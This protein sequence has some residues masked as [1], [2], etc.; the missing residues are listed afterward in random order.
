M[1]EN[2]SMPPFLKFI[3][4]PFIVIIFIV[5]FLVPSVNTATVQFTSEKLS[6][7]L[8]W[9]SNNGYMAWASGGLSTGQIP[10]ANSSSTVTGDSGLTY[11]SGV[12]KVGSISGNTTQFKIDNAY[13]TALSTVA[14]MVGV[15]TSGD[16]VPGSSGYWVKQGENGK[17]LYATSDNVAQDDIQYALN[18]AAVNTGMVALTNGVFW[19][20]KQ[21]GQTYAIKIPRAYFGDINPGLNG[22]GMR[23]VTPIGLK[24]NYNGTIIAL[25]SGQNC[26]VIQIGDDAVGIYANE[27]TY[28]SDLFIIG[29]RDSQTSGSG[30]NIRPNMNLGWIYHCKILYCKD[31]GIYSENNRY[32]SIY[33]CNADGNGKDGIFLDGGY[34]NNI[35]DGWAWSNGYSGLYFGGGGYSNHV[36]GFRAMCNNTV[37]GLGGIR[38]N[39]T[40]NILTSCSSW[41]EM[42]PGSK[43]QDYGVMIEGT[44]T[45]T[46]I[47]GCNLGVGLLANQFGA[48]YQAAGVTLTKYIDNIGLDDRQVGT[49]TIIIG[50]TS[51]VISHTLGGIPI[52]I[53][54]AFTNNT[55]VTKA[56]WTANSSN[57]TVNVDQ[58][59]T[60]DNQTFSYIARTN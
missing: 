36:I 50:S 26:D 60:T 45:N 43:R 3:L 29:N 55:T 51:T 59:P 12:L 27:S 16:D 37:A 53:S 32:W 23:D 47:E 28:V 30:I 48:L 24:G 34:E 22:V 1:E 46:R 8:T 58:D 7:A 13:I 21:V 2:K 6:E 14:Y 18:L 39:G 19:V 15:N 9:L 44:S 40:G 35:F 42:L 20:N 10:Y 57:F 4:I 56:W 17:L 54:V 33:D 5:T 25:A 38:I 11:T 49:G 52:D 31:F 41:D